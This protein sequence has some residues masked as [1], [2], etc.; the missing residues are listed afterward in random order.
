MRR[1]FVAFLLAFVQLGMLLSAQETS[2]RSARMELDLGLFRTFHRNQP[3]AIIMC[4]EGCFAESQTPR[5]AK[6]LGV[7]ILKPVGQKDEILVGL[8]FVEYNFYEKGTGSQGGPVNVPYEITI[9]SKYAGAHLG[10]RWIFTDEGRTRPYWSNGFSA[11]LNTDGSYTLK[12]LGLSFV[13]RLGCEHQIQENLSLNMSGGY[14]TALTRYNN[15][16]LHK[17]YYPYA[18]GIE[19]GLIWLIRG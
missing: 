12:T 18:Y 10:Y 7:S 13:T 3:V 17:G 1:S 14:R 19:L 9:S 11:E 2:V 16:R 6:N 15:E 8:T 4:I 5:L